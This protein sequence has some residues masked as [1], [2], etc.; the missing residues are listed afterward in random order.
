MSRFLLPYPRTCRKPLVRRRARLGSVLTVVFSLFMFAACGDDDTERS[1]TLASTAGDPERSSTLASISDNGASGNGDDFGLGGNVLAQAREEGTVNL[2][3]PTFDPAFV[4]V[5]QEIMLDRYGIEVTATPLRAGQA[6]ERVRTEQ[7]S[8]N[9]FIDVLGLGAQYGE[10]VKS[11]GLSQPFKPEGFPDLLVPEAEFD[12]EGYW[13]PFSLTPMGV[14][15]NRSVIDPALIQDWW[16]LAD[17]SIDETMVLADPALGAAGF[18]WSVSMEA[19]SE[20]GEPFLSELGTR[21]NLQLGPVHADTVA[22]LV[23][24]DIG[25]YFPF[26]AYSLSE[27]VGNSADEIELVYPGDSPYLVPVNLMLL[28][29]APHPNA[30]KVFISFLMSE[31]GQ[32]LASQ[33]NPIPSRRGI[34][35][36]DPKFNMQLYGDVIGTS[37][38][39]VLARQGEIEAFAEKYFSDR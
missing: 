38:A 8:G 15:V 30:A 10:V 37:I 6:V 33:D 34:A 18:T 9:A 16:S 7:S 27:L 5:V 2:G 20:Y 22:R 14:A 19:D 24:G 39:S 21:P 32:T 29:S 31:E 23:R 28:A 12:E 13:Y 4:E 26:G 17:G 25:A 36:A 35:V 3:G 11:E 1:S